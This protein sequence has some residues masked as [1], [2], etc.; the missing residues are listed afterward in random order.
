MV[1]GNL[2]WR[3]DGK[4]GLLLKGYVDNELVVIV[5]TGSTHWQF[6]FSDHKGKGR[7]R[8]GQGCD[9]NPLQMIEAMFNHV[10]DG[11]VEPS[12]RVQL[13]DIDDSEGSVWGVNSD[14]FL[15]EWG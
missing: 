9:Y 13:H 4:S 8:V 1:A 3:V 14:G 6:E 12:E 2:L 11:S 7:V 15:D 10:V 5:T